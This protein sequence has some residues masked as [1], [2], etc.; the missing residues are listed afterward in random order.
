[1]RYDPEALKPALTEL[2]QVA[3]S[4]RT[5]ASYRYDLT[6]VTR[7]VLANES[8]RL[9]PLIR[10]AYESKDREAFK[11]LTD[12]WMNGM[13][14]EDRLLSTNEYFLLGRWL[15]YVPAWSGSPADLAQIEYDAHSI[16]TTWGDRR[17][18]NEL[19]EYANR[20]W[21]GLVSD[22]Y[23]PRWR[24]YFDS[25]EQ[26]LVAGA[27]PKPIDWF[28]FGDAWNRSTKRYSTQTAGDT[29]KV[30]QSIAESMNLLPKEKP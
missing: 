22:Y 9:L 28:E 6:D 10:S 27:Q 4:L 14:S 3:P 15:G 29:Y 1:M 17:A 19:H 20:D 25:L 24:L 13:T 8:R 12:R 5:C 21:A 7:Q 16:L 26:A 11:K 18:S 2:L 23:A 30:S